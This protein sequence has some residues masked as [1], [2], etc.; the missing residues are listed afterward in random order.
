MHDSIG[1]SKLAGVRGRGHEL[2]GPTLDRVRA[3]AM[4]STRPVSLVSVNMVGDEGVGGKVRIPKER[5]LVDDAK[6]VSSLA[7]NAVRNVEPTQ[8]MEEIYEE[9]VRRYECRRLELPLSPGNYILVD[10]TGTGA[11]AGMLVLAVSRSNN[12][13][14]ILASLTAIG[15]L[16]RLHKEKVFVECEAL[17]RRKPGAC[18]KSG[19]REFFS[20]LVS[21]FDSMPAPE[22]KAR[23]ARARKD[24]DIVAAARHGYSMPWEEQAPTFRVG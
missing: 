23:P 16:K 14:L 4:G 8:G 9:L 7:T 19:Y 12:K 11:L 5:L 15:S 1:I 22:R 24:C 6:C 18:Q 2:Y 20:F 17:Q 10:M 3:A 13:K 21:Y